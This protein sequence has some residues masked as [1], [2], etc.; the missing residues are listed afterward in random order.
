MIP[1]RTADGILCLIGG[2]LIHL[3]IG[4]IYLWGNINVYVASY[5]RLSS[6]P[7][8]SLSETTFIFPLWFLF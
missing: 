8:L 7:N 2:I 6:D 3:S 4:T 5:Y 1:A